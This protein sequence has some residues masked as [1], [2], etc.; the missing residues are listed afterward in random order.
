MPGMVQ[1]SLHSGSMSDAGHLA[2]GQDSK[3]RKGPK[4][5]GP[6]DEFVN[7]LCLKAPSLA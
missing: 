2:S 3:Q 1:H 5:W 4:Q 6:L 7:V